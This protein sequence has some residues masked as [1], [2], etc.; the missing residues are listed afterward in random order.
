VSGAIVVNCLINSYSAHSAVLT[1]MTQAGG[2][3]TSN[4]VQQ[5]LAAAK[6][7]LLHHS[8]ETAWQLLTQAIAIHP[9][10]KLHRLRAVASACLE[11]YEAALD[12]A[13]MVIELMPSSPDG[14]YHK[15]F[16]LFQLQD[17]TAAAHA[18]HEGLALNP[19][20]K[21]M[22]RGFWDAVSL[23]GQS[24]WQEMQSAG[25]SGAGAAA[26]GGAGPT[27]AAARPMH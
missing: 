1:G 20:D 13:E 16:A 23:M 4:T 15:G 7:A 10:Y 6:Q 3:P 27:G 22:Q 12:D 25:Q 11:E 5:L 24:A 17:Y 14:Y 9:S 2:A 19:A 8:F 26:G 21:I 18:F